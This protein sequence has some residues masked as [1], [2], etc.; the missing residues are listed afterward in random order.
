LEKA[1]VITF[2]I[3]GQHNAFRKWSGRDFEGRFNRAV[4]DVMVFY[5]S[6]LS[7][8]LCREK[9]TAIKTAFV[10]LCSNQPNFIK[11]V[12]STTKSIT[13]T[14][15]RLELWGNALQTAIGRPLRIPREAK[16][17]ITF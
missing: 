5:F 12:E 15:T 10:D 8:Q 3:F 17:R 6:D 14:A 9:R 1:L 16:G 4:F 2:E 13:E 7:E 11:S